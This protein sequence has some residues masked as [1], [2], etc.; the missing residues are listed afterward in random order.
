MTIAGVTTAA[1]LIDTFSVP[2]CTNAVTSSIVRI[3]PPT[4]NGMKHWLRNRGHDIENDVAILVAG[5][6]VEEDEFIRTGFV[7]LS[8]D[9]NWIAGIAQ[10]D[11]VHA[12]D[13][14]TCLHI[15]TRNDAVGEQ[16]G[17][18]LADRKNTSRT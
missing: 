7:V 2:A 9:F 6:D 15:Q 8:G 3:P 10:T 18:I 17:G 16:S 5:G 1:V 11:K 13:D 14:A 4:V 12:L